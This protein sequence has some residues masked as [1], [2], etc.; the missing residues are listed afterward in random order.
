M[1]VS[2]SSIKSTLLFTLGKNIIMHS[3]FNSEKVLLLKID[4]TGE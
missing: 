1:S 3:N 2:F 4:F